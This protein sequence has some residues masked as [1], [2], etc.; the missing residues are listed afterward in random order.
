VSETAHQIN[1][2]LISIDGLEPLFETTEQGSEIENQPAEPSS[3][4]ISGLAQEIV[5]TE[6]AAK[7]L[8]ISSR[9]V[10]KRLQAGSL[11]G[12]R[13]TT[14]TRS[15]WRIYWKEPVPEPAVKNKGTQTEPERTG[16]AERTEAKE[17]SGTGSDSYLIEL[18]KKLLEQVQAL[19]YRNGY[20]QSQ[21]AER[22]QDIAEQDEK[23][24]LLTDS[25]HKGGW[26][27]K[28]SSWFMS[29]R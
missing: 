29:G 18:N 16:S 15:E 10:I 20:L 1:V 9:A 4:P 17:P 25:E 2:D 6:E 11:Q 12:F 24:K 19:T 23:I 22:E 28:F 7:R 3:E 5:S 26:W 14:K 27:S 21:L 13:D 8:G